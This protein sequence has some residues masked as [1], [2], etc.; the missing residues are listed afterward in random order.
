MS[1]CG[2]QTRISQGE[3]LGYSF[4]HFYNIKGF[5]MLCVSLFSE[6]PGNHLMQRYK[7]NNPWFCY[8]QL[9]KKH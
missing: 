8:H 4:I 6:Q 9:K 2:A 1:S 5:N 3:P 7:N